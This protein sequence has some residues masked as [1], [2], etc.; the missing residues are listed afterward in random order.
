MKAR[1]FPAQAE[2]GVAGPVSVGPAQVPTDTW[3]GRYGVRG[4]P[5]TGAPFMLGMN[6]RQMLRPCVAA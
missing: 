1:K 5:F 4:Q 3:H 6:I 2:L